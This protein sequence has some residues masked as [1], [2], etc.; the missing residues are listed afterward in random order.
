MENQYDKHFNNENFLDKIRKTI[1]TIPFAEE[2]LSLYFTLLD[3]ETSLWAEGIIAGALGY[4]IF[5]F[6]AIPD[7]IP[8]AGYTD[9]AAVLFAAINSLSDFIKEEHHNKAKEFLMDN[10]R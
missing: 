1:S 9:D 7:I 3:E 4:F 10:H 8:I 6:D 2:A 5:P